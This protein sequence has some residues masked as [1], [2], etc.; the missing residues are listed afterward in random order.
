MLTTE[1]D[2]NLK[3]QTILDYSS[4]VP[5]VV[6]RRTKFQN[7]DL[8]IMDFVICSPFTRFGARERYGVYEVIGI[9]KDFNRYEIELTLKFVKDYPYPV[10][11]VYE[12][13][14]DETGE[15]I[16]DESDDT[17]AMR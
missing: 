8:E 11:V 13:L 14:T 1:S 10:D 3:A 9:V 6:K 2:A 17:I 16:T 12:V 4:S 15:Y 5:S 7:V